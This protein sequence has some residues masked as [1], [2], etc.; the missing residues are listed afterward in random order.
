MHRKL[1]FAAAVAAVGVIATSALGQVTNYK[2][3]TAQMLLNPSP[4]DWLMFSRTYDAQ[5]FSPLKQI[6]PKNVAQLRLVWARG[7]ESG[8]NENIPIV[9]RGVLYGVNPGG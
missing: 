4:D 1:F 6:N 9:Y 7:I 2:P 8:T 3:V 5:R